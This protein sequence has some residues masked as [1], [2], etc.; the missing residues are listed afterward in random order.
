MRKRTATC[1]GAGTLR[2]LLGTALPVLVLALVPLC[3]AGAARAADVAEEKSL[4][5]FVDENV[6][7][8]QVQAV[9][10]ELGAIAMLPEGAAVKIEL[11]DRGE[12]GT[13]SPP[14]FGRDL[15]DGFTIKPLDDPANPY[16][17]EYGAWDRWAYDNYLWLCS[18]YGFDRMTDDEYGQFMEDAANHISD[19]GGDQYFMVVRGDGY[20][21]PFVE[22][23]EGEPGQFP[24]M[25]WGHE[26]QA[27]GALISYWIR[28]AFVVETTGELPD[29]LK[30]ERDRAVAVVQ[31]P[32]LPA[33][34]EWLVDNPPYMFQ[35]MPDGEI[36]TM[37]ELGTWGD[38][39]VLY[40]PVWCRYSSEGELLGQTTGPQAYWWELYF[41]CLLYTS[42]SPRD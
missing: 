42:P 25:G 36:V 27:D 34:P 38:D 32:A 5:L 1:T 40:G 6:T 33:I 20:L 17:G 23:S 35:F 16:R 15:P 4:N 22:A 18:E 31:A 2:L 19:V 41:P 13:D 29:S 12:E 39:S 24:V 14:G 10:A 7:E 28:S 9:L 11:A 26:V 37:G 30:D 21:M 8:S 3:I